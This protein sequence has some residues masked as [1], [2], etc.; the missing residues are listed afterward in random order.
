MKTHASKPLGPARIVAFILVAL[1][2]LGL[3]YL[4]FASGDDRVSVPAGARAGQLTMKPCTY[5]TERG[6]Y[7]ADCGTLVVPENRHD[8]GSRLIAVPVTRIHARAEHPGAPIFRLQ[9]GPGITNMEFPEASRFADRHDVVLVGYRGVD[10]STVL[11]CPEVS[12][13]LKRSADFLGER[14]FAAQSR[15]LASCA[16]RLRADGVDLAGYSLAQRVDDL[17][18]A[19]RALGYGR[20]DLL[21]ESVGTRT[22]QIY[23]WRYPESIHRSVMIGVNPPGHFLWKAKT[24]DR[25]IRQYADLCAKDDEC[26]ARTGDLA[27]TVKATAADVPDRW[28][29]LSIKP[30]HVR[31][32]SFFGLMESTAHDSPLSG[33]L[34]LDSWVSAAHGDASGLWLQSLVAQIALPD[35]QVWGDVAAVVRVDVDQ[36]DGAFA[37]A[38]HRGSILGNPGTGVLWAGGG[39]ADAWPAEPDEDRYD[40]VRTSGTETLLIGGNLD[41]STPVENATKE[42]L[43][44][45][46]NGHQVVLPG[47]GHTGDFWNVQPD[48]GSR[49]VNAFLDT[50]KVD[51]SLYTSRDV[52]F[53]PTTTLGAMA[54]IMVGVMAGFAAFA[55]ASLLWLARRVNRRGGVGRKASALLR[56]LYPLVLGL[57]G[58]FLGA[59]L[60]LA[61]APTIPL[62]N[63]LLAV[64]AVG[65]PIGLGIYWAWVRGAL[66][67]R[68]RT[69]GFA[70]ALAGAFV[71]AWFGFHVTAGLFAVFTTIVGAAAGANLILLVLDSARDRTAR[72]GATATARPAATS[73]GA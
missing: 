40:H 61:I 12:S 15:A 53:T 14:S 32:A 17:E 50:G 3:A 56:S 25:Q 63:E 6:D 67:P 35:E 54:K 68:A 10:G 49:L 46:P 48:A 26:R 73:A 71:G 28:G 9:G 69:A 57:G 43:P 47:F 60:V 16:S 1:A 29:P 44:H 19:R 45:L 22:A 4:H 66:A 42:L 34:A 58:W 5:A 20:V 64:L 23:S 41:F 18:A 36:P 52:D 8:A 31:V 30:G 7:A 55:L 37:P 24:T 70:A 21:S 39:L 38:A 33:P 11:D 72:E 13:A 62:D 65:I 2:V 51:D 27:A 59:L